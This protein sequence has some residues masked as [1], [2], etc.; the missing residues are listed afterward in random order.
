MPAQGRPLFF[1]IVVLAAISILPRSSAQSAYTWAGSATTGSW[2]TPGSWTGGPAGT[3]PGVAAAPGAGNTA[4][5]AQFTPT[6]TAQLGINF[7]TGGGS[8]LS[9]GAI[10]F[11]SNQ[12]LAIGNGSSTAGVLRLNGANLLSIPNTLIAAGNTGADLT[13]TNG[14]AGGSAAMG[15]H[16]GIP[17]GVFNVYGDTLPLVGTRNLTIQSVIAEITAGSGFTVL[18]GGNLTLSAANTF[19]GDVAVTNARV[20]VTNNTALGTTA[21]KTVVAPG[22]TLLINGG[23]TVN[24][25][26][27]FAGAGFA[28][29]GTLFGALR[30]SN[31][32][33]TLG[34]TLTLTGDAH[35]FLAGGTT[36][37]GGA[38]TETGGARAFDLL[39]PGTLTANTALGVTGLVAVRQGVLDLAGGNGSLPGPPGVTISLGGTLR[40]TN[41]S[42]PSNN[43]NRLA[44]GLTVSLNNGTFLAGNSAAAGE[45]YSE[46]FGTL[47]LP[48]YLNTVTLSRAAVGQ[49]AAVTF[50]SFNR[51][52][53]AVNFTGTGLGTDARAR[54]FVS[55]T[56]PT[57]TNGMFAPWALYNVTTGDVGSTTGPVAPVNPTGDFAGYTAVN[58]VTVMGNVVTSLTGAGWAATSNVKL[59]LLNSA[60]AQSGNVPQI[61]SLTVLTTSTQPGVVQNNVLTLNDG[62]ANALRIGSGGIL[63]AGP[64]SL[65]VSA[66]T[67]ISPGTSELVV[68]VTGGTTTIQATL[69]NGAAGATG[70]TKLGNG[71][72]VLG[73]ANTFS[74][75]I[76][77]A[78]GADGGGLQAST[79]AGLGSFAAPR[80]VTLRAA[81]GGGVGTVLSFQNGDTAV[82]LPADTT[83]NLEAFLLGGVANNLT[84]LG[85]SGVTSRTSVS[86]NGN[87]TLNGPIVVTGNNVV[88]FL[89]TDVSQTRTLITNGTIAAGTEGFTGRVLFRGGGIVAVNG[90]IN[91]PAATVAT[92][93]P[94]TILTIHPST[95]AA[96]SLL[97]LALTAG[98]AQLGGTGNTNILPAAATVIFGQNGT[99]GTAEF[100][101]NGNTQSIAQLG[102]AAGSVADPSG[103][104]VRNGAAGAG[105][106]TFNGNSTPSTFAGLVRDGAAGALHLNVVG[107]SLA[108]TGA[109]THT[110][111]TTVSA[112]GILSVSSV[113]NAGSPSALG[114]AAVAP[115]NLVFNGG[116]LRYTGGTTSTNRGFTVNATGGTV[117]VTA[118]AGA[119]TFRG[120]VTGTGGLVKAG[121]GTLV[122]TG[123]N[124]YAGSTT[125]TGGVLRI[126]N[127]VGSGTGTGGTTILNNA[128][129]TLMGTGRLGGPAAVNAN[130]VLSPGDNAVGTLSSDGGITT[131]GT[132]G[133]YTVEYDGTAGTLTTGTTVDW[134]NSLGS[135]SVTANAANPFVI[136]LRRVAGNA[137][138]V[139]QAVDIAT[140]GSAVAINPAAFTFTGDFFAGVTPTI[141]ANGTAVRIT[142]APLA[143]P[144][145]T[146]VWQA[147]ATNTWG[148]TGNWN[149]GVLPQPGIV[150]TFSSATA[151]RLATVNDLVGLQVD[152]V[153]VT[154]AVPADVTI[155]GNP[156][157]IMAAPGIDMTSAARNLTVNTDLT[158]GGNQNWSVAAGR[159]LRVTGT[160]DGPGR[161][162]A[163]GP[164]L[165]QV[166]N[167]ANSYAGGTVI[168]AGVLE[169][170]QTAA[171][172]LVLD[173][174]GPNPLGTGPITVN[175]GEL[176]LTALAPATHPIN[177]AG[178]PFRPITFGANGGTLAMNRVVNGVQPIVTTAGATAPAVVRTTMFNADNWSV[179]DGLNVNTGNLTGTGPVR[180]EFTDGALLTMNAAQTVQMTVTFQGVD[181]GSAAANRAAVTAT[182]AG[183]AANSRAVGRLGYNNATFGYTAGLEFRNAVQ[184]TG[185]NGPV[186]VNADITLRS[187]PNGTVVAFQGRGT[188]AAGVYD[189]I[190]LGSATVNGRTL[191]I[192]GNATAVIDSRFRQ[193][194]AQVGGVTLNART[195]IQPGGTLEFAQ[196]GT[197]APGANTTG[198][199]LV[200][201]AIRG[202]GTDAIDARLLL[203]IPHKTTTG[204]S[205]GGVNWSAGAALEVHGT[206]TGGLRVEGPVANLIP[207]LYSAA[208]ING[209]TGTGGTLTFAPST[210]GLTLNLGPSA[211]SAVRLGVAS[212]GP[213]VVP[214]TLGSAAN[215][216]FRW[217]GLVVKGS[218]G[219]GSTVAT[220]AVNQTFASTAVTGGR[221]VVPAGVTLTSPVAVSGGSL[222]GAGTVAG[223]LSVNAG[224][225]LAPGTS[226]GI[227]TTTGNVTFAAGSTLAL[228]LN[229]PTAGNAAN[230]HDRLVLAGTGSV[231]A[232]GNAT[233]TASFGYTPANTDRLFIVVLNDGGATISG[234]FNGVPQNGTIS[235]GGG[236]YSAQVSY[237]GNVGTAALTGGN[238]VVVYNFV[239]V[240]E[241]VAVLGLAAAVVAVG[242]R[243]YR[244]AVRAGSSGSRR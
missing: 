181:N 205:T 61:H 80:S 166:D 88:Q 126:N 3:Y 217:G 27:D 241:P 183:A 224:G 231:L 97:G 32:D 35:M 71:L 50:A 221:L 150:A 23:L 211:A 204:T 235:L 128:G 10:N 56:A 195:V 216:L 225:T 223:A 58:G 199:H 7:G 186:T 18:G 120:T 68:H 191:T 168:T 92:A 4:D 123:T 26:I 62:T 101:L 208:R 117:Q 25:N 139:A 200:N 122:L 230:N 111:V 164:G 45:N 70:L 39:G 138:Q 228:E 134:F 9:L 130:T 29:A 69:A 104:I 237:T 118:P 213:G 219:G 60:T 173:V 146:G 43:P 83:L 206:G 196:S 194:V 85:S 48:S 109:N 28:E 156:F 57:V 141:S 115:S 106:L 73:G 201:G 114:S 44:N 53:G 244:T 132:G 31:N 184:V 67:T 86:T 38:L 229:G 185:F 66:G 82:T 240:P 137:P 103:M 15:L 36:T 210:S 242:G 87:L 157:S 99:A 105:T 239:P 113:S 42:G 96:H 170:T 33:V 77:I 78:S 149:G 187:T 46:T 2:Y 220:L 169:V 236:T 64:H 177:S 107:G 158:L 100:W 188:D 95:G 234:T 172:N 142:F 81:P 119:V 41:T 153:R 49:T 226:P 11:Q 59:T 127:A 155:D 1:G 190:L 8:P 203:G 89:Q 192:E 47:A 207:G 180:F 154:A 162:T 93:D 72:L 182:G 222:G 21:G 145:G 233:L 22:G 24:E 167:T 151:T 202:T 215:D 152:G 176:R 147:T 238:D 124:S 198:V 17:N 34:G 165:I 212:S 19:T 189:T 110:G 12:N 90:R 52:A 5:V 54:V 75:P 20:T 63:I 40:L 159:T 179:N 116:V 98:R 94:S 65:Q 160:I 131:W 74:G 144:A 14:T 135:L 174:P 243:R 16:L 232:L 214:V 108:L 193:D 209:V 218:S 163:N 30:V 171:A 140:F 136:H 143:A 112:P 121:P 175:G 84:T 197:T 55:P 178:V 161:V 51:T 102:I 37:L 227:L 76:V 6:V 129:T 13:L 91:L 133:Q 125:V 79:L 148:T